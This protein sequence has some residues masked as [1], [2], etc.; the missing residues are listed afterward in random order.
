M[1]LYGFPQYLQWIDSLG[2][3]PSRCI[4]RFDKVHGNKSLFHG[5]YDWH[6]SVHGHWAIFRMDLA[7][8][9]KNHDVAVKTSERF[10][11]LKIL[12]VI[13][14]LKKNPVFE[15]PY[16]RAWLL[17]LIIEHDNWCRHN[18]LDIPENLEELGSFVSQSLLNYYFSDTTRL[19]NILSNQY[20]N[21]SFSLVQLYDY[22]QYYNNDYNLRRISEY[23]S[24]Y[25]FNEFFFDPKI[26]FDPNA[27]LSPFWSW[28]YIL[29]K[30]MTAEDL[31]HIIDISRISENLLL[32]WTPQ[33][34]SSKQVHYYGINWS[35][36]WAIKSLAK[37][38][39]SL[40]LQKDATRFFTAYHEH[41]K[42][43]IRLHEEYSRNHPNIEEKEAYYSYYHWVPQF[44]I[45][46]LSD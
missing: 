39:Q 23:I 46:A 32:P 20:R 6:S 33:E 35:R 13:D 3:I 45:Y 14:D 4:E 7:G 31:K 38:I 44:G 26:E 28:V 30:T 12:G 21:D 37:K 15:M 17:R 10:T 29:S 22:L 34:V 41:I 5:C 24:K 27:F 1:T 36:A 8:T 16:G 42:E 19:P 2:L 11:P 9:G 43:S 25:F 18:N 40:G